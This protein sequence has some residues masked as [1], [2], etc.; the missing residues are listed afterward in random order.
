M[1]NECHKMQNVFVKIVQISGFDYTYF[2]LRR[3]IELNLK[4]KIPAKAATL[5]KQIKIAS[6]GVLLTQGRGTKEIVYLRK[7]FNP[8]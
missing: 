5:L 7:I 4:E 2:I 3:Q 1:Y 8:S 6:Q